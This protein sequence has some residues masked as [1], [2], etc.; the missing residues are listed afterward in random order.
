MKHFL[1]IIGLLLFLFLIY[2]G[3][4]LLILTNPELIVPGF[5]LMLLAGP[6]C[7]FLYEIIAHKFKK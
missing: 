1:L 2:F 5:F 7:A 4:A 6:F 3:A